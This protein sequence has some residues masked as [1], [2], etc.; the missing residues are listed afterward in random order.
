MTKT[1]SKDAQASEAGTVQASDTE[2]SGAGIAGL[3]DPSQP[4]HD[5]E[6]IKVDAGSDTYTRVNEALG[7]TFIPPDVRAKL[8]A[9]FAQ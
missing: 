5:E 9:V 8:D 3:T 2:T 6:H 7:S 1:P 4:G